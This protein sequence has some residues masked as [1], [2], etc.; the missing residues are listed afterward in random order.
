MDKDYE[1]EINKIE[2][3]QP[4]RFPNNTVINIDWSANV[5]FGQ[6]GIIINKNG[7]VFL[8]TEFMGRDF[9]KQILNKIV[10]NADVDYK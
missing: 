5:G 1:I 2:A 8:D 10:D 3:F 4:T 7:K 6:L 9:A